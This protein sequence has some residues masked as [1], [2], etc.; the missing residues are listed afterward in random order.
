MGIDVRRRVP[1]PSPGAKEVLSIM[2]VLVAATPSSLRRTPAAQGEGRHGQRD[3]Y[4]F[5][6]PSFS[7]Q[8]MRTMGCSVYGGAD[9]GEC[10]DRSRIVERDFEAGAGMD[11]ASASRRWG[12]PWRGHNISAESP[13]CVQAHTSA[14]EFYLHGNRRTPIPYLWGESRTS[15]CEPPAVGG[16]LNASI[17]YEGP[18]CRILLQGR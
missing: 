4:V 9:I 18:P 8:F 7:F 11:T 3:G 14:T 1:V 12:Q 17:A 16:R 13:I 2:T 15:S 10:A 5:K 6:D